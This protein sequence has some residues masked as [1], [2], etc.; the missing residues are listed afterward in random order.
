MTTEATRRPALGL[1]AAALTGAALGLPTPA[2]A[3]SYPLPEDVAT[4]EAIVTA[5]Y[6]ALSRAPGEN[7]DWPRFRSLWLPG[8]LMIPNTEQSGGTFTV[9]TVDEF[10]G[11][12]DGWYAENAPIGSAEDQGFVEA[13]IHAVHNRYGDVAQVMSTY[14]KHL[15]GSDQ[16]LGRGLNSIQLVFDGERWWIVSTAWDE[17]NG[18]GPLPARYVP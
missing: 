14:Q 8:G 11:W 12:V 1:F 10:I 5:S 9:M 2:G 15:H 16:I 7:F 13:E 4:P 18:A 17:E 6:E 3:Q